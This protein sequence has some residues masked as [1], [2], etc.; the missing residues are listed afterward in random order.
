MMRYWYPEQSFGWTY[1]LGWVITI[2]TIVLVVFLIY[3]FLSKKDSNTEDDESLSILKKRYAKGEID[4]KKFDE[5]K[6]DLR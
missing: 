6:K 1:G 5:M 2:L 4:K 3:S